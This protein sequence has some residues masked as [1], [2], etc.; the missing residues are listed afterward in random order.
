[1]IVPSFSGKKYET[2]VNTVGSGVKFALSYVYPNTHMRSNLGPDW[3]HVIYYSITQLYMKSG[4][5]IFVTGGVD[6]V[7]NEL[8]KLHPC[9]TF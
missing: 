8:N 5:E 7:S 3:D 9:N 2:T 1:M 4:I 6:A